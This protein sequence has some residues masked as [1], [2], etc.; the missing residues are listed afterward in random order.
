[1]SAR[2]ANPWDAVL[3]RQRAAAERLRREV[4]GADGSLE[5]PYFRD[6]RRQQ[7]AYERSA[8]LPELFEACSRSDL[9]YI[10]DFHASAAYQEFA[11]R[12]LEEMARRA[13]RVALGVEFIYTRQ[14]RQLDR[15][16]QGLI[17]DATFLRRIHYLEEWGYPWAGFGTLLD[18][19]RDLGLT[20]HALDVPPRGGFAGLARRDEHAARRI[21][22]ILEVEPATRLIVVYGESHLSRNHI[23]RRVQAHLARRGMSRTSTTVFQDP[24]TLYW[25]LVS[26]GDPLPEAVRLSPGAYA[27]FHGSPLSKYESYRQVLERWRGD[28]PPDGDVD[29]TPAVHHLIGVLL[30][31]LGIRS[32]R[33]RVRHRAGWSD[34]LPD[35]FPEVYSGSEALQILA[36][37]LEEH[38]RTPEEIAEAETLLRDV[39]RRTPRD[40]NALRLLATCAAFSGRYPEAERLLR[41]VVAAAPDYVEAQLDLGRLFKEQHRLAAAIGQFEKA[42]ELEPGSFQGH[43]LLASVLAPAARTHDAI[44]AYRKALE[45]RPRHAG[46][47]LGLGHMLKTAGQQEEAI[48]AYRECIRLKPG[49]GEI[50]WSLAN[51]KTYRLSDADIAEIELDGGAD[52]IVVNPPT[53]PDQPHVP[54]YADGGGADG[55]D[56]L[57]ALFLHLPKWLSASGRAQIVLSS[58]VMQAEEFQTT[59]QGSLRV[60]PVATIVAPFRTFYSD[61]YASDVVE[62]F[63]GAGRA[64]AGGGAPGPDLSELVTVYTLD[65]AA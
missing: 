22:S 56:F 1:V 38:R 20:V 11:A 21:V 45:L 35:A 63:L 33:F 8:T 51:L 23:P 17:G 28:V 13:P 53:M 19:A 24:D 29:L 3:A 59:L 61:A 18:R 26:I 50:Y 54:E 16:Q 52:L 41:R 40:V 42:I 46:A 57:R 6:L 15:R 27:V 5:H 36:S 25:K 4:L 2:R 37:I 60:G 58:L 39:L 47:W 34:D 10:G 32:D 64:L 43:F 62:K 55:R 7:K 44:A 49:N 9:V 65:R 31:W 30:G 48:E 14:Q 12:V